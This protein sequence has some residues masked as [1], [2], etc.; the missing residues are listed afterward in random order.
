MLE[1]C[2]CFRFDILLVGD[3][4]EDYHFEKM[5]HI[6][7]E[8]TNKHNDPL[9]DPLDESNGEKVLREVYIYPANI[10]IPFGSI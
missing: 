8:K 5:N 7:H 1:S 6:N 9:H 3:K 2:Y 4:L 10:F